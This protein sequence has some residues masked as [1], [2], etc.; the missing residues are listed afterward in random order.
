MELL[1]E[2][3]KGAAAAR[4]VGVVDPA[5]PAPAQPADLAAA[6]GDLDRLGAV[7]GGE[8]VAVLEAGHVADLAE[9]GGG[10]DRPDPE[11]AGQAGPG[12]PDRGVELAL[13]SRSCPSMRR[14]SSMRAAASS[15]RAAATASG[16]LTEFISRAA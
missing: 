2:G 4:V 6:G 14:K 13:V 3:Y 10:N 16:G 8:A 7:A 11:Q 5:V 15:Q 12:R 1:R 9:D